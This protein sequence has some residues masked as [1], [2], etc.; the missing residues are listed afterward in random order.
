MLMSDR[1]G[2]LAVAV[3]YTVRSK[4]V[5]TIDSRSGLVNTLE[6][7]IYLLIH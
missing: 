2:K 3:T 4:P 6:S 7:N 1:E 5:Y